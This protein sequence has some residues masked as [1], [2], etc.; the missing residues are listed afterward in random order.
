M[1]N[2]N[3]KI[4]RQMEYAEF[5]LGLADLD[6]DR[7]AFLSVL[8]FAGVRVS[9]AL[10]LTAK[11]ITCTPDT[12]YIQ[13]FRLKGSK[14]TDPTPIPKTPYTNWVCAQIGND[15]LF[16]W[17]RK[18]GYNIVH[19]AFPSMYPHFFRMNRITK[20]SEKHG[21]AFVYSYVGICAQSIDHYRGKVDIKKV[22]QALKEELG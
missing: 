10:A 17:C 4:T 8:F 18:T 15:R 20:I 19:R 9:E 22:G 2:Y 21:D 12:I 7:Q 16:P 11:D 13:F 14:Q 3:K 1:P 5:E 6:Q